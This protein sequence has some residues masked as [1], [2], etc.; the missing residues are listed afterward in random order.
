[1]SSLVYASDPWIWQ[2]VTLWAKNEGRP[3]FNSKS[4]SNC[5]VCVSFNTHSS[6]EEEAGSGKG[7]SIFIN[8]YASRS[9]H[10]M[11]INDLSKFVMRHILKHGDA[12]HPDQTF[13]QY[14]FYKA[15]MEAIQFLTIFL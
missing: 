4:D 5:C 9:F 13:L 2:E 6:V 12:Y 7:K 14:I 15:V 3:G 10:N 11:H 8:K 1:M